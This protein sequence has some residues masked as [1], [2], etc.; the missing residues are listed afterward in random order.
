MRFVLMVLPLAAGNVLVGLEVRNVPQSL[1]EH[2]H[3]VDLVDWSLHH[4]VGLLVPPFYTS[5]NG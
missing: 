5:V 3:K 1:E 4:G 2:E